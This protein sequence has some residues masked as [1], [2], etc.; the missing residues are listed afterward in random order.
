MIIVEIY[1][2]VLYNGLVIISFNSYYAK[3]PEI[4]DL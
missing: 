2:Y 3:G 1:N 4:I